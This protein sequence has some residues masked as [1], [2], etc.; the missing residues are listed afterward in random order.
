[1]TAN[2]SLDNTND[3]TFCGTSPAV[4][5][6]ICPHPWREPR[7]VW[8]SGGRPTA[9]VPNQINPGAFLIHGNYCG[10]GSRPKTKPID[11]LDA[12]CMH[13][14]SCARPAGLA[15]CGCTARLKTEAEAVARNPSQ[16]PDI[17]LLA[18]ATAAVAALTPC[19]T[20]R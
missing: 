7:D 13:H 6:A 8:R 2:D 16:P 1:M 3:N 14:D 15:Q 4:Q 10:I 19:Q 5:L 20:T 17:Q 18:S 11:A 9:A 12:A